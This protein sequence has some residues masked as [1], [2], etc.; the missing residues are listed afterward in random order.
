[1]KISLSKNDS[2]ISKQASIFTPSDNS[3]FKFVP[4]YYYMPR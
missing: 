3:K 1:M 2:I 4:K